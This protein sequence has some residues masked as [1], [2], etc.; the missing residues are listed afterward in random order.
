MSAA[1]VPGDATE[2]LAARAIQVTKIYGQ[3][4]TEVRALDDDAPRS[5]VADFVV[6]RDR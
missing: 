5:L 3:G 2:T 6:D 4:Q 1:T